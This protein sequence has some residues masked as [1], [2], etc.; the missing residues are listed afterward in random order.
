MQT[1]RDRDRGSRNSNHN[2]IDRENNVKDLNQQIKSRD[3]T[4]QYERDDAKRS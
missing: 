3:Q 4:K 2:I 1:R